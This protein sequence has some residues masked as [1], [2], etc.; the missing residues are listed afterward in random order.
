M[1]QDVQAPQ[2][3]HQKHLSRPEADPFDL[4]QILNDLLIG[5]R[6][7]RSRTDAPV[8]EMFLEVA[9]VSQLLR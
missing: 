9:Q 2:C 8:E 3:K 5:S 4:C 6:V 7:H 1:R